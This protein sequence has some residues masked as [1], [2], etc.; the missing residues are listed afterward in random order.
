MAAGGAEVRTRGRR[1]LVG[2]PRIYHDGSRRSV[3]PIVGQALRAIN[4]A[5][6]LGLETLRRV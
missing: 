3:G 5:D 1:V 2:S 6:F 4:V